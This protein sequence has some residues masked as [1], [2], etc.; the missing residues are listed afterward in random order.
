MQILVNP[1]DVKSSDAV[2]QHVLDEVD[3]ALKRFADRITRV[4]VHLRDLNANK[5]G[6]AKRCTMEVRLA[7]LQPI[8]VESDADDL[9]QAIRATAGKLERAVRN[10]VERLDEKR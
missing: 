6:V 7:G 10:K 9:Y 1:G 2:E 8:A 3:G 5:S 4:E